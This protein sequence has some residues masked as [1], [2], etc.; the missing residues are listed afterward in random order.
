MKHK[1][2]IAEAL[3]YLFVTGLALTLLW[4]FHAM[5]TVKPC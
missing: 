3:G 1:E 4:V 5:L 2:I